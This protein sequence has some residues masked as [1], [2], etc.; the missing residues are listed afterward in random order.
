MSEREDDSWLARH[1][2][3]IR[4]RKRL[5][6]WMPRRSNIDRYPGLKWA[7]GMARKRMYLWSFRYREVAPA[8]YIGTIL[9]FL[10]LIGIKLPLSFLL[11]LVLRANLPIFIA[12]QFIT[13][14]FT[15]VPIYYVC[16]QI[17]CLALKLFHLPTDPI[18]VE[19]LRQVMDNFFSQNWS[20]K[21]R[22]LLRAFG[23]TCLGGVI[24]GSFF[25]MV[26]DQIYRFMTWRASRIWDRVDAIRHRR[27]KE[28]AKASDKT[29][30]DKPTK[31]L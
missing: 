16:Y 20:E 7:A 27:M 12:V 22:F 24:L 1:Y 19:T 10:P 17:G 18:S 23:V 29:E 4:L 3:Q 2:Q 8:L 26:F 25:G 31:S 28:A 13:N 11:A 14:W 6:R 15:E 9:S 21:G 5:L 30:N